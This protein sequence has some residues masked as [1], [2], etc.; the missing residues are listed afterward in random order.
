MLITQDD[1]NAFARSTTITAHDVDVNSVRLTL[2]V[3]RD[4]L[5]NARF[6][7]IVAV[8][9]GI[10]S[11]APQNGR[12]YHGTYDLAL[13]VDEWSGNIFVGHIAVGSIPEEGTSIVVQGTGSKAWTFD[14]YAMSQDLVY[15][16]A[17][18]TTETVTDQI[19]RAHV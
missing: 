3:P 2:F 15:S 18:A 9:P 13:V 4:Q 6:V 1:L 17:C 7:S 16:S 8:P 10:S 5:D 19:G 14:V 12:A 11:V